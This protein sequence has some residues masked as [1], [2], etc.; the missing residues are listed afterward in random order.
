MIKSIY[1]YSWILGL[2]FAC[3]PMDHAQEI[4]DQSIEYHGG[5][6]YL[7]SEVSFDF[8]GRIYRFERRGGQFVYH[9]IWDDSTGNVHDIYS[10]KGFQRLINDQPV[11]IDADWARRYSNS[12]NSVAYFALLPFGLNDPAVRKKYMGKQKIEGKEYHVIR[13]NFVQA[14]GGED[15]H[16]VF[17]FWIDTNTSQMDFFGYYYQSDGGG[18]R[19]RKAINRRRVGGLLFEDYINYRGTDGDMDVIGLATK[20][21]SGQ[22]TK[23]SEIQL[24]NLQVKDVH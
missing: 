17:A 21:A 12:I 24:E 18:I 7:H 1:R 14:G 20:C 8:R 13:V 3:Q 9:R 23:L 2:F 19:F 16:D 10:N 15:Y 6:K 5:D 11:D 4:I 22:M